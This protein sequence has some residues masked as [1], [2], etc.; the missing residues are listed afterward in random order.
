M[1]KILPLVVL[2]LFGPL[3]LGG[4]AA[5]P[6]SPEG[7]WLTEKHN[8]VIEIVRCGAG[9]CGKLAWFRIEPDSDNPRALDLKNPDP[10]KRT[11]SL[12]ALTFMTG[13]R[14]VAANRWEDGTIYDP[15]SGNTYHGTIQLRADGRLDLHGYIGI[16]LIGRS[17][18]WTRYPQKPPPC[19]SR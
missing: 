13:F 10:A 2:S 12:C 1:R 8:G 17:E 7:Y 19:P 14:P 11:Q 15:D 5:P 9:L 3:A 4:A 6:A 18:I 16:S